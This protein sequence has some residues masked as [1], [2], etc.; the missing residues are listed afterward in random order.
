MKYTISLE[1]FEGPFDLLYH[2]IEKAE[3]DIYDIP[4]ARIA[5]QYIEYL[6]HM[7]ELDLEITSEFLIMAATLLEIKSRMLLPNTEVE[8]EQIEMEEAD[9]REELIRRLI[10]YKRYKNAAEDLKSRQDIHGKVFYKPKEEIN[11]NDEDDSTNLDGLELSHLIKAFDNLIHKKFKEKNNKKFHEIK[12]EEISIDEAMNLIR[13]KLIS[14]KEVGFEELF[15][16]RLTRSSIV[17]I[18]IGILELI[19]MKEVNIY[20]DNNFSNIKLSKKHR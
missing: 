18:F 3:V 6:S 5:E 13:N 16:N 2:L 14:N 19:K 15:E 4:I 8:G 20:Q 11:I 9:P 1:S 12:R 7:E 10:E 17:T